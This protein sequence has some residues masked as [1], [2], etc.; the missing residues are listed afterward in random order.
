M[1]YFKRYCHTVF[2]N[3]AILHL[4]ALGDFGEYLYTY[5]VKISVKGI[6]AFLIIVSIILSNVLAFGA[7]NCLKIHFIDV[8]EGDSVLI[9]TPE[10][11]TI[12][13]DG[14]NLITGF[15]VVEY[16][17]G[18]NVRK[19]DHL[20]FTHPHFDHI[21]GAFF[22]LQMLQVGNIYD[23]GEYLDKSVD[24]YRW[25]DILVRKNKNYTTLKVN[26]TL[27]LGSV[28]LNVLWP[29]QSG[30]NSDFNANSMV[31]MCKYDKF[32]CLLTG[33]LTVDGEKK[34]LEQGVN[35]KA[36]VLKIGHHGA[37]DANCADFLKNIAPKIAILSVDTANIRGYPDSELDDRIENLGI[38]MYRTDRDGNIILN[39][40]ARKDKEPLIELKT[41]MG[42]MQ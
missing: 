27:P 23:N 25:Y 22:I 5:S 39:I 9:E 26:K 42:Q 30:I 19:I 21:G 41:I 40:Y 8:G 14:G 29:A 11:Q 1:K 20:I 34:L 33:D 37:A 2:F 7:D 6:R 28:T 35:L 17:R 31:L 24:I 10:G 18:N 12:L 3:G 16:L 32:R 36:D 13:A 4:I 38:R 15:K